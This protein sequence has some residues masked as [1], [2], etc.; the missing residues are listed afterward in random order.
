[1]CRAKKS[2]NAIHIDG[3]IA[4]K[5]LAIA[6]LLLGPQ[7]LLFGQQS[8][9]SSISEGGTV[10]STT[11]VLGLEN[12]KRG[13]KGKLAIAGD[14]LRFDVGSATAEVSIP[15]IQD[16]FTDQD[17]KQLVRGKKGTVASWPCPTKADAS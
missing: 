13:A 6:T 12:I 17:S 2:D 1:M 5:L 9:P 11:H 4:C 16:V 8:G 10:P 14:T 3:L 7:T 15:S